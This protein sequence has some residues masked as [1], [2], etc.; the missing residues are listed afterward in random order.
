MRRSIHRREL[1]WARVLRL[2]NLFQKQHYVDTYQTLLFLILKVISSFHMVPGYQSPKT[3]TI[4]RLAIIARSPTVPDECYI[5]LS[6]IAFG[7]ILKT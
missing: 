3:Y 6:L 4:W 2:R 7:T 5:H 1:L